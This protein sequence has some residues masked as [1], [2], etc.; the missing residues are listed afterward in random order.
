M[1]R[2]AYSVLAFA[3][4]LSCSSVASPQVQRPPHPTVI[5]G[6]VRDSETQRPVAHIVVMLEREDSGYAGQ[7]ETDELGKFVLNGPGA[8][9]FLVKVRAPGYESASQRVD[10]Q[11]S[12]TDYLTFELR[13]IKK[14]GALQASGPAMSE[15]VSD[16]AVPEKARKEYQKGRSLFIEKKDAQ[17]AI[18]HLLAAIKN[19]P[20]YGAAH[21]LLGMAYIEKGDAMEA[22]KA[23]EESLAINPKSAPAYMALGMLLNHEKDYRGAEAS[24]IRG[25]ELSPNAPQGHYELAKTYWALGRWQEAEPHAQTA[26]T[27]RPDM[28]VAHVILGNIALRRADPQ[29]AA[30]EFR[31]YLRLE[32][33]GPMSRGVKQMLQKLEHSEPK[34]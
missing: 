27:L 33:D 10:L 32:P 19:Y 24:L 6:V 31:E 9:V 3:V 2:L 28:A 1:S 12:S 30:A 11:T 18:P 16:L 29:K 17:S 23:L 14:P 34:Q 13:P 8:S 21:E 5:R 20:N 26:L 4:L 7:S 25:L 15:D 22:R